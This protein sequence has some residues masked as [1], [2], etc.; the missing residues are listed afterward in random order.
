MNQIFVKF[1]KVSFLLFH[2]FCAPSLH[3]MVACGNVD[4]A[5]L[6]LLDT[7][8]LPFFAPISE[9]ITEF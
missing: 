5:A 7:A 1:F 3:S 9:S 8:A 4:K 2:F 6:G